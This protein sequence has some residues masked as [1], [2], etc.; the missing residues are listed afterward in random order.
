MIGNGVESEIA[1]GQTYVALKVVAAGTGEAVGVCAS[2]AGFAI[3]MA[4]LGCHDELFDSP[5]LNQRVRFRG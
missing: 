1:G 4:H 2:V 3:P 5:F